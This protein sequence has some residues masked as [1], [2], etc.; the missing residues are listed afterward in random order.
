MVFPNTI[1]DGSKILTKSD[2]DFGTEKAGQYY[3]T[4]TKSNFPAKFEPLIK[5][6]GC[7]RSQSNIPLHYYGMLKTVLVR[8]LHAM[9]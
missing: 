9:C 3:T 1:V 2:V 6:K 8:F 7:T 4:T 5:R